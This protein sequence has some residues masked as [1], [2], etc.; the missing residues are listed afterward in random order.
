[1]EFRDF[2]ALVLVLL[3]AIDLTAVVL[4]WR[5]VKKAGDKAGIA[6]KERLTVAI[7]LWIVVSLNGLLGWAV[8]LDITLPPGVGL[9]ILATSLILVSMPNLYWLYIYSQNKFKK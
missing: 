3:P 7:M 2:I 8:L 1:M 4:L 9:A 5:A 6:L